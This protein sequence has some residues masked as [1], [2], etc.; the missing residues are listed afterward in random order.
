MRSS[1]CFVAVQFHL[2]TWEFTLWKQFNQMLFQLPVIGW[3][4]TCSKHFSL[5]YTYLAS[6]TCDQTD[7][8]TFLMPGANS[9]FYNCQTGAVMYM[10]YIV[11]VVCNPLSQDCKCGC[12]ESQNVWLY[13]YANY[14][15]QNWSILWFMI[16]N[17]V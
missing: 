3:K 10:Y 13:T 12:W 11:L 2:A 8:N 7:E 17:L 6:S 1:W 16:L 5:V 4:W 14:L 9:A 15:H